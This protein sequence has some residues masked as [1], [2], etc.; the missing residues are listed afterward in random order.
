MRDFEIRLLPVRHCLHDLGV[1]VAVLL[2]VAVA[3]AL[4]FYKQR[5][6][7]DT[8]PIAFAAVVKVITG[9]GF[10]GFIVARSCTRSGVAPLF[11]HERRVSLWVLV[12]ILAGL[13]VF[14]AA[15]VALDTA[16]FT[17]LDLTTKQ[18]IDACE[19]VAVLVIAFVLRRA[20]APVAPKSYGVIESDR[21]GDTIS[22]SRRRGGWRA[23][24]WVR[25]GLVVCMAGASVWVV[26]ATPRASGA[27]VLVNGLSLVTAAVT[28]VLVE[29][30]LSWRA[31]PEF[32]LMI[33]TVLPDAVMLGV[34]AWYLGESMPRTFHMW[35]AL[36]VASAELLLK[37]L[38][39]HLLRTVGAVN[40]SVVGVVVFA[41]VVSLDVAW[42][43]G[44]SAMRLVAL[45]TTFVVLV[46]YSALGYVW[47]SQTL[48]TSSRSD[49][50]EE[51]FEGH[52][53][54]AELFDLGG[55]YS[56]LGSRYSGLAGTRPPRGYATHQSPFGGS[57]D[58]CE[59]L[60]DGLSV[61]SVSSGSRD[62]EET[63]SQSTT[64]SSSA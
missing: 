56:G 38:G 31:Y 10:L 21:P 41:L 5:V 57:I 36:I 8:S 32:L 14:G 20:L 42:S 45:S 7:R 50:T 9:V 59:P 13:C 53:D 29:T 22:L 62:T 28:V 37:V 15:T 30:L 63:S 18:V 44:V 26:W 51:L 55:R 11:E 40:L 33:V 27:G 34:L 61:S 39:F 49:G 25:A 2:F 64:T 35:S 58:A 3:T 19:P 52:R 1:G 16:A 54:G 4:Q 17:L 60:E 6:L 43:G 47:R 46:V 48:R 23:V 24:R 12:P